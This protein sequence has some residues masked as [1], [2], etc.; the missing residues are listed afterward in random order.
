MNKRTELAIKKQRTR[1]FCK[2]RKSQEAAEAET[3]A[4]RP[5]R[6]PAAVE[7][8]NEIQGGIDYGSDAAAQSR[9]PRSLTVLKHLD[10]INKDITI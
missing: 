5:S 9:K 6:I 7:R 8:L 2:P 4:A 10:K 1:R 3:A